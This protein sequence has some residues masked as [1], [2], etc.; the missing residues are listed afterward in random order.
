MYKKN[1]LQGRT[2]ENLIHFTKQNNKKFFE[3]S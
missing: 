1:L 3:I 2:L